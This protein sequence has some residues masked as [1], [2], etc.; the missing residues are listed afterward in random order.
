MKFKVTDNNGKESFV[1][2]EWNK[3]D[4]VP[5]EEDILENMEECTCCLNESVN[6]CEGE[7]VMFDEGKVEVV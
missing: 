5:N 7:C 1:E 4:G 2:Y 3:E 6:H